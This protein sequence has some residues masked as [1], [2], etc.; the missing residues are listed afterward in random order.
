[1]GNDPRKPF[2]LDDEE[3]FRTA[4]DSLMQGYRSGSRTRVDIEPFA[5][6]VM[7][8]YKWADGDGK[9][10]EWQRHDLERLLL[11]YFPRR[12]TV[13]DD[14]LL[15]VVPSLKDFLSFLDRR[16]LLEG[17]PLVELHVE[18]NDLLPD[19]VAAM[20]DRARF[21]P[22]KTLVARMKAEGVDPAEPGAIDRWF[23]DF[24]A[25]PP[26]ERA[27]ILEG[28]AREP[29]VFPAIELPPAGELAAAAQASPALHR[30]A[31]FARYVGQGRKLTQN[32]HLALADGRALVELLETGDRIDQKIGDRE[33]RTRSTTELPR[34]DLVFRWARAAG[35]VKVRRGWVSATRRGATLDAKPMEDWAAAFEGLLRCDPWPERY[36]RIQSWGPYW[37]EIL[38]EMLV[39]LPAVLY[40]EGEI[41]VVVLGDIA[42]RQ[43]DEM[44][45]FDPEAPM[46]DTWRRIVA[47]DIEHLV[48]ANLAELGAVTVTDGT[49][50]L[51]PIGRWATNRTLRARGDLAPITG[52]HVEATAAE[53]LRACAEL[54][55]DAADAEI[56]AWVA[57][58]AA[59]AASELA[60]T[61]RS[62]E[63]PMLALH[64]LGLAGPAAE[65]EVRS[66][67]ELDGLRTYAQLWLVE[68]GHEDASS[69]SP[70]TLQAALASSLAAEIDAGG[71]L[72]AVAQLQSLGDDSGQHR[73]VEYLLAIDHPRA[74]EILDVIGR[75]HPV[76]AVAKAARKTAFRR[77]SAGR[78]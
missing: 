28:P 39:D 66:M 53:L 59:T 4:H 51:T 35:F 65:A 67:L 5:A 7:L 32:G 74:T 55:L 77:R 33:F 63:L 54:P 58:R 21:G 76:K 9:I 25:R 31:E 24:N 20:H 18:L 56:R 50:S 75:H 13:D 47:S 71:P 27:A 64:A 8:E 19:F 15:E 70:E 42:W 78:G 36:W 11:D 45:A 60:A 73:F 16:G 30:L 43:L 37:E 68:H 49:I 57:G 38:V 61:A 62:G 48:V 26:R 6:S 17:D 69:L 29:E 23:A 41:D 3:A 46:I 10:C 14:E 40:A 12:V 1:M 2:D 52:E 34:L 44:F 22:A 72:A